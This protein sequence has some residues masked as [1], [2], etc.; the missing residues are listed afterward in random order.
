MQMKELLEQFDM[1]KNSLE[2]KL[3]DYQKEIKK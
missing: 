3:Q 2:N 1:V